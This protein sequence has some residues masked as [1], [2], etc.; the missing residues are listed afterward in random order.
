[1]GLVS[2]RIGPIPGLTTLAVALA[3]IWPEPRRAVV[4]E[5]DPDGGTLASSVSAKSDP[6]LTSLAA[7][8][9]RYLSPELIV[10]N[11]SCRTGKRCCWHHRLRIG[12]WR[13]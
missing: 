1:M 12:R 10:S 2:A 3:A 5:L 8:G 9:R 11:F 7:S 13:T 6:G 4:V